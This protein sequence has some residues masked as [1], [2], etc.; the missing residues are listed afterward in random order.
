MNIGIELLRAVC[1]LAVF[2]NH[3]LY[4]IGAPFI[5]GG[6]GVALFFAISGYVISAPNFGSVRPFLIKRFLRIAPLYFLV[7]TI[8]ILIQGI[9]DERSALF[10]YL[11]ISQLFDGSKPVFK[12][13]WTLEY[14]ML[15]YLFVCLVPTLGRLSRNAFLFFMLTI[16]LISISPLL[17]ETTTPFYLSCFAA[18][19]IVRM[20]KS[21][22]TYEP[23]N[24]IVLC[25]F[26]I[27]LISL[28]NAIVENIYL[29]LGIIVCLSPFIVYAFSCLSISNINLRK[30]FF[31]LGSVTFGFYLWHMFLIKASE[32]ISFSA[33]IEM[34]LII[35]VTYLLSV[36]SKYIVEDR[37]VKRK[38]I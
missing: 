14:E 1:A 7:T 34:P 30:L 17:M 35:I 38:K 13:G 36:A 37:F 24:P 28:M 4:S 26:L 6:F 27:I 12:L 18:G 19:G 25:I 33:W 23:E 5:S 10:S 8:F 32:K 29:R 31:H 11:F 21:K 9:N 20:L 16:G 22:Y 15:F 3:W 2:A